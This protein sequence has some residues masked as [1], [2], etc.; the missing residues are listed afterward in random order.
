MYSDK[1]NYF[2]V[3]TALLEAKKF[4]RN[5]KDNYVFTVLEN[6]H[7]INLNCSYD[8]L[9]SDKVDSYFVPKDYK[10]SKSFCLDI[11]IVL[12][13]IQEKN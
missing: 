7:F 13:Y 6:E 3:S 11:I 4:V 10:Y 1:N 9:M 12:T 2:N 5:E 8:I